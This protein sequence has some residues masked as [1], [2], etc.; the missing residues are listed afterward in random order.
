MQM[1]TQLIFRDIT[2][3]TPWQ[4]NLKSSHLG[5]NKI[6]KNEEKNLHRAEL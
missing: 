3:F 1:T 2:A 6:M 5:E 4:V